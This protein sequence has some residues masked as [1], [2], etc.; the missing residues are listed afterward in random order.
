VDIERTL[1]HKTCFLCPQDITYKELT[2]SVLMSSTSHYSSYVYCMIIRSQLIPTLHCVVLRT[3][4]NVL[5]IAVIN[6][7]VEKYVAP[8]DG[9]VCLE[10]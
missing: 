4:T 8:F 9:D 2:R 3:P 7:T 5:C 1:A 10:M 6:N